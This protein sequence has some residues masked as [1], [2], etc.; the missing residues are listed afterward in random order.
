[1]LTHLF[2]PTKLDDD[3]SFSDS[4]SD[5]GTED[6]DTINVE[7]PADSS[8]AH[9][10]KSPVHADHRVGVQR[11]SNTFS[12]VGSNKGTVLCQS[13][14]CFIQATNGNTGATP[15]HEN[16]RVS[17]SVTVIGLN[18]YASSDTEVVKGIITVWKSYDQ[19]HIGNDDVSHQK[20]QQQ[21]LSKN[22]TTTE[23]RLR[24]KLNSFE[25]VGWTM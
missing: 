24:C 23:R 19:D 25:E 1:V 20:Q 3:V 15:E 5:Y 14:D 12:V 8:H 2:Q 22:S 6:Y 4:E 7:C 18:N 13:R 17:N 10:V 9:S 11:T 21:Q 16:V